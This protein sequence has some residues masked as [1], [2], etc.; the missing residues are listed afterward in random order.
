VWFLGGEVALGVTCF[1]W[2]W[3][4]CGFVLMV[5]A[6]LW[7]C[8]LG[9]GGVDV[10]G[11]V[12]LAEVFVLIYFF[13]GGVV[14]CRFGLFVC[15]GC[16]GFYFWDF[17]LLVGFFWLCGFGLFVW[18]V[19]G[20]VWGGGVVGLVSFVVRWVGWGCCFVVMCFLGGGG[21]VVC[22]LGC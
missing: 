12:Y 17:G 11:C 19:V 22:V 3:G 2:F 21:G 20:G 4:F 1:V 16:Y 7:V 5:G 10:C 14:L 18:F 8:G 15:G 6:W 9:V 13:F